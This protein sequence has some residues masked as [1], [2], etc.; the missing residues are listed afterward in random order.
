LT[1]KLLR[2]KHE[3]KSLTLVPSNGGVFE[4]TI[5]GQQ[6]HSKLATGQFPEPDAILKAARAMR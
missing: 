3:I 6:I 1:E 4:V 5:N 2:L